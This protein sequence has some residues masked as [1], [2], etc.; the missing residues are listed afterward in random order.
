MLNHTP[1]I[2]G[3]GNVKTLLNINNP[4]QPDGLTHFTN[5]DFKHWRDKIQSIII[6]LKFQCYHQKYSRYAVA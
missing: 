6:Q 5:K 3:D 4:I 2:R 1:W